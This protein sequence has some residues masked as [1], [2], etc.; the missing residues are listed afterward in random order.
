M[1]LALIVRQTV[2]P[3]IRELEKDRDIRG[4]IRFLS[5]QNYKTRNQAA[6]ALGRIGGSALSMLHSSAEYGDMMDR[7]GAVEAIARIKNPASISVLS[8]ILAK[9]PGSEMRWMA[10]IALGEL[11]D[12]GVIPVLV[13]ALEDHDKYVRYGTVKSLEKIGWQ[14]DGE[15]DQVKRCVA[16]QEWSSIPGIGEVPVETLMYYF[17]DPDPRIRASV[18]SLLGILGDPRAEQ[19]CERA[20]SDPDP[21]VRW[22]ASLAFPQCKVPLLYLPGGLFRRVRTQKSILGAMV[23]NFFF[24]GLGYF[25]LGK[26]WGI[27]L[28]AINSSVVTLIGAIFGAAVLYGNVILY[29]LACAITSPL[30][31]HTWYIGRGMPDI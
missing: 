13:A 20:M 5:D 22:K 19:I 3:D 17:D 1:S 27:L 4:L 29:F 18:V 14:P 21:D 23:L 7:L 25:Y 31:I 28:F 30:V 10:A 12:T 9:D 26:W 15:A 2:S 16:F 11:G 6:D 24:L 8:K